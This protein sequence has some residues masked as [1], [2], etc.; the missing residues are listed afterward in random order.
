MFYIMSSLAEYCNL[1]VHFERG[2]KVGISDVN[3]AVSAA[4]SKE[5]LMLHQQCELHKVLQLLVLNNGCVHV[6]IGNC[7]R[8]C[9]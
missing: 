1:P 3:A 7:I 4:L 9:Y 8:E 6:Q 2:R 5:A